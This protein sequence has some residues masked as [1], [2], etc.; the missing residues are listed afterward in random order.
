MRNLTALLIAVSLLI[1]CTTTSKEEKLAKGYEAAKGNEVKF[2]SFEFSKTFTYQDSIEIWKDSL[3]INRKTYLAKMDS[4]EVHLDKAY[5]TAVEGKANNS[6]KILEGEFDRVI[7]D[8]QM[9]RLKIDINR[10]NANEK[11][12]NT[13]LEKYFK[14]I[15][16]LEAQ[17]DEVIYNVFKG[18]ITSGETPSTKLYLFNKDNSAIVN[19]VEQ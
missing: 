15:E 7:A 3:D 19:V 6:F 2:K 5:Q 8:V 10:A 14:K 13:P 11:G 18:E 4:A 12:E 9:S 16:S 17:K 1:G